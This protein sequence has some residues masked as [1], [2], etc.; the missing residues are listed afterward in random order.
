MA[1]FLIAKLDGGEVIFEALSEAS[2]EGGDVQVGVLYMSFK[3][4][5]S[6]LGGD[7]AHGIKDLLDGGTRAGEG[8]NIF[9]LLV[10]VDDT[11]F[12]I[13][14][15]QR[16]SGASRGRGFVKRRAREIRHWGMEIAAIQVPFLCR[17]GWVKRC[18]W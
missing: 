16:G 17:N 6:G 15:T 2:G 1:G 13:W 3:E 12:F 14:D 7:R 11:H 18:S 9:D 4:V 10:N 5:E 8:D